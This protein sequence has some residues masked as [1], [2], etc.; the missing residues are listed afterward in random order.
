MSKSRRFDDVFPRVTF[1][2]VIIPKGSKKSSTNKHFLENVMSTE[3][4][5][6]N[7]VTILSDDQLE[8]VA[9]GCH[10]Y[11][12]KKEDYY[13]KWEKKEYYYNKK[14]KGYY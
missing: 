8:N 11:Y 5:T 14:D 3:A 12:Y 10:N 13:K 4:N 7:K 2:Y 9:G 6:T 1:Y